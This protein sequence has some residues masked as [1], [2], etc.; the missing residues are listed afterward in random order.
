MAHRTRETYPIFRRVRGSSGPRRRCGDRAAGTVT[1]AFAE[2][3]P[4][5]TLAGA[6][7]T[8][9]P[10]EPGSTTECSNL[11]DDDGDGL[12][13]LDDPG[14][15]TGALDNLEEDD[16]PP[17][18]SN[19]FDDDGDGLTDFTPPLGETADPGCDSASD[20]MEIDGVPNPDAACSNGEDDD[21]DGTIDFT[22]LVGG[23]ADPGCSSADDLDEGSEGLPPGEDP[24][25]VA[26]STTAL[27]GFPMSGTS[28]AILSTGNSGFADD[29][30]DSD[31][32]GQGNGGGSGT[33]SHGDNV[34]DL[35]TLR[36]D[37]N[38]PLDRNCLRVDFRFLSDE[39][40]E[41]VGSTVNDAFLA[42][43]DTSNFTINPDASVNAP[44]NFAYDGAGNLIS[45][46]PPR[47][48][49]TRPPGRPTTAQPRACAPPRRS[50]P[51]PTRS[52]SRSST[53]ATTSTTP[54]RSSTLCGWTTRRRTPVR[55]VPRPI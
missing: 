21:G 10:P 29:P 22:A 33:P 32:T 15:E 27:T 20:N 54:P 6:S 13:D 49:P 50:R 41:F 48:P 31:G 43:L 28:Y 1:G 3:L 12:T 24:N 11:T 7:F 23:T 36:V 17:E 26:V 9:I 2:Q 37:V 47:S 46:T 45:T 25:P 35:V 18:C 8:E 53:R 52:T 30:N 44:N 55:R 16:T 4:L 40:P 51:E 39:F 19:G 5:G 14:C 34:F 38:V 42:E